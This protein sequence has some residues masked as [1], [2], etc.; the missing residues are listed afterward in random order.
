MY[1]HVVIIAVSS[2]VASIGIAD[3]VII[4]PQSKLIGNIGVV[5]QYVF[6][7]L[8]QTNSHPA[9]Q[10][11]IDYSHLNGFYAGSWLSNVSWYNE[12]NAGT[13]SLPVPLSSPSSIGEPY[14]A[15]L[16]LFFHKF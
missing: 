9:I 13:V 3:D 6:R 5:S 12:Q 4:T 11:G 14:I 2:L 16:S 7:G 8:A 10:G 1:R 15:N